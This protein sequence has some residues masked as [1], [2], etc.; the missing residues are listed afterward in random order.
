MSLEHRG[1]SINSHSCPL[2]SASPKST[3]VLATQNHRVE[4]IETLEP[5]LLILIG[6]DS[7]LPDWAQKPLYL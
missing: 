5:E 6:N 1:C 7:A 4:F 3:H 2:G